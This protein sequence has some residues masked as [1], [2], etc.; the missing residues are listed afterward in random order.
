MNTT[1]K[2]KSGKSSCLKKVESGSLV[3]Q[4]TSVFDGNTN[5]IINKERLDEYLQSIPQA[6]IGNWSI[7]QLTATNE[8]CMIEVVNN[9]CNGMEHRNSGIKP[10]DEVLRLMKG[11]K[12]MMSPT[13]AELSDH[14]D[15]F[16]NHAKGDILITGLGLGIIPFLLD[17]MPD[18]D[19]VTVFESE[20]DVISLVSDYLID[21]TSKVTIVHHNA[22][23]GPRND[24]VFDYIW[25]DIWLDI[26]PDN[27]PEMKALTE[28]YKTHAVAQGCWAQAVCVFM[29]MEEDLLR[30]RIMVE[31]K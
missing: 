7:D 31:V 28:R 27:L 17:S 2:K 13:V 10:G 11:D 24:Q 23:L 21:N 8:G 25:H 6:T 20:A 26:S 29:L 14:F 3:T 19:S 16:L 18:V 12:C 30:K 15:L 22:F 9:Q 4:G 5:I 1:T